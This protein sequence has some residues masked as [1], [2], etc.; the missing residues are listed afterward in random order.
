MWWMAAMGMG[1]QAS[2]LSPLDS[3]EQLLPSRTGKEKMDLAGELAYQFCY[4]NTDKALKYGHLELEMALETGDSMTIAQAWNDLGA[5]H[6]SRGE[7]KESIHYTS[8]ALR[9][10]QNAGDS[11]LVANSCNKLGYAW[12]EMG[13]PNRALDAFLRAARIYSHEGKNALLAVVYNN[14]GSVHLRQGNKPKAIEYLQLA[15]NTAKET[16]DIGTQITSK[17]NIAGIQF[18]SGNIDTAQ[19]AYEELLALIAETGMNQNLGTVQM[20]LGACYVRNG[21]SSRGIRSLEVADSLFQAKGDAKGQAMTKVNLAIGYLS[22]HDHDMA[23]KQLTDAEALCK[24][25]DSDQQWL[26]LYDGYFRLESALGNVPEAMKYELLARQRREKMYNEM[27]S[28]QIAQMETLYETEKKEQALQTAE[29]KNYNQRLVIAGMAAILVLVLVTLGF[30]VRNQKLKRESL[31][32]RS[33]MAWQEERLRISRDLHD[34]IGAE[35]TLI[36][37][38][39]SDTDPA[40]QKGLQAIGDYARAAMAQLRET[41]WAI[42]SETIAAEAFANR[43][44]DY[45]MRLCAPAKMVA[46]L[47]LEGESGTPLRPAV[48]LQLYRI[49]QEAIHN[50][51]K[52]AGS[53]TLRIKVLAEAGQMTVTIA[54]Q[55]KGFDLAST[56][57]GDGIENMKA[58]A[59][60]CNGKLDLITAPGQ[61]TTVKVSIPI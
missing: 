52:Y 51:V 60:E 16:G 40:D 25:V 38:C 59:A 31:L 28:K 55:G 8:G 15:G 27:S 4:V 6:A 26:L 23:R 9:V 19:A 61:G 39:A 58:R 41:V 30:L 12:H 1:L 53:P 49:C 47:E 50:A 34:N 7:F 5:V 20:N 22:Q 13:V 2:G 44:G 48:T 21:Q 3:L 32:Q 18:E 35:L 14:I 33:V 56:A 29:M 43:L 36:S 37:T 57:R 45:A 46:S 42:R 11:L 10:R 54:D 17:T 24:V